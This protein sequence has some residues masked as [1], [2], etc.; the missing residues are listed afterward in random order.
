MKGETREPV[1]SKSYQP[2]RGAN[3]QPVRRDVA[4]D[5]EAPVS[6]MKG[7]TFQC[8][9]PRTHDRCTRTLG[10]KHGT[11]S[12]LQVCHFFAIFVDFP[13]PPLPEVRADL[14]QLLDD[15]APRSSSYP[16][17]HQTTYI[18]NSTHDE[19]YYVQHCSSESGS[20]LT[21][22][23]VFVLHAAAAPPWPS[24]LI[25][26]HDGPSS[27]LTKI[28]TKVCSPLKKHAYQFPLL[29]S[30]PFLPPPSILHQPPALGAGF[31]H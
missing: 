11:N 25:Q 5:D 3:S 9:S 29:L 19:V 26:A 1:R 22:F 17:T 28:S 7:L 10:T 15:A 24:L 8:R 13:F 2:S 31:T 12:H 14:M 21:T 27:L 23:G 20:L 16:T 4:V 30:L 6:K 18:P